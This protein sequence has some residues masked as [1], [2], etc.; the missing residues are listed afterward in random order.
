MFNGRR[1]GSNGRKCAGSP[2]DAC[3]SAPGDL[4]L[5][6]RVKL[7]GPT[8][9]YLHST[10][11]RNSTRAPTASIVAIENRKSHEEGVCG[12]ARAREHSSCGTNARRC[13]RGVRKR[14]E[15]V[16]GGR[17]RP[18]RQPRP[19]VWTNA[20]RMFTCGCGAE[21][22]HVLSISPCVR[23][24]ERTAPNSKTTGR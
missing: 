2:C 24:S 6:A 19:R 21:G 8:W 23:A 14:E 17:M 3:R 18:Q 5:F 15:R 22:R 4:L 10:A 13:C 1:G 7:S 12:R 9:P 20:F 11:P 16:P